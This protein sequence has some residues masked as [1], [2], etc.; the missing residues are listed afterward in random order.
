MDQP[1]LGFKKSLHGFVQFNQ[2]NVDAKGMIVTQIQQD[3]STQQCQLQEQFQNERTADRKCQCISVQ[4][5]MSYN[6]TTTSAALGQHTTSL[7]HPVSLHSQDSFYHHQAAAAA[8]FYHQQNPHHH[9][10]HHYLQHLHQHQGESIP[11][12]FLVLCFCMLITKSEFQVLR[13][14]IVGCD[15]VKFG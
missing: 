15:A 12:S 4:F 5:M 13:Q 11:V 14:R 3:T 2:R 6:S 9:H 8:A 7:H 10:H 1:K